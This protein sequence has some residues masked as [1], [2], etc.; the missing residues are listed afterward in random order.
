MTIGRKDAHSNGP[1]QLIR[2]PLRQATEL[3]LLDGNGRILLGE[4]KSGMGRGKVLGIGGKVE[5]GE[6]VAQAAI[7]EMIEETTVVVAATDLQ[8]AANISFRFPHQ[9]NW[10][11]QVHFF[12]AH[13]WSGKP[14]ETDEIKPVWFAQDALPL[15]RMWDDTRYWLPLVLNDERFLHAEFIYSADNQTVEQHTLHWEAQP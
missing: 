3:F 8:P 7:R 13:R 6:T 5:P 4:K 1:D 9:Q 14:V 2:K 15:H 12:L 11:M 10:S